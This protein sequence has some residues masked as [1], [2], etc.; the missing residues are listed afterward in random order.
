MN[1]APQVLTGEH[2]VTMADGDTRH[3]VKRIIDH[4]AYDSFTTDY[5][6]SIIELECGDEIDFSDKARPACLPDIGEHTKT[7]LLKLIIHSKCS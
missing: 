6:Y 5:D 7:L 4:P 1:C 2:D 3:N